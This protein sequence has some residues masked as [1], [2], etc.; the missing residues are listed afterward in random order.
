LKRIRDIYVCYIDYTK[1][2]DNV[3]HE[4]QIDCLK[5]KR[6]FFYCFMGYNK[7]LKALMPEFKLYK[8][9]VLTGDMISYMNCKRAFKN[10]VWQSKKELEQQLAE[11]INKDPKSFFLVMRI[12]KERKR[13]LLAPFTT[14]K[15][16]F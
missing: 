11:N 1:A 8:Q 9:T 14:L 13:Q 2:F 4:Q 10:L 7:S 3:N 12:I 6:I 16:N 15:G 5:K